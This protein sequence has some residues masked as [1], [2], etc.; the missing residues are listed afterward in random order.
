MFLI[1]YVLSEKEKRKS[2]KY[3]KLIN[4]ALFGLYQL[5]FGKLLKAPQII[6]SC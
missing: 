3:F 6:E 4:A 5:Q 2:G 1:L